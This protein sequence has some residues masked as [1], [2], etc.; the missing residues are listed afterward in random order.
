MPGRR[1]D[2]APAASTSAAQNAGKSSTRS[3]RPLAARCARASSWSVPAH[4]DASV[5]TGSTPSRLA[6]HR[7][8]ADRAAASWAASEKYLLANGMPQHSERTRSGCTTAK[9]CASSTSS[10]AR[11]MGV[12]DSPGCGPRIRVRQLGK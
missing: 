6:V 5:T 12:A 11:P 3:F 8:S 7:A 1:R 2:G 9:P 4:G 10:I